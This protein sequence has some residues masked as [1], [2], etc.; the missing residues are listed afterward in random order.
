MDTR[1]HAI[2][3]ASGSARWL[4]CNPSARLEEMLPE[5]KFV[6]KGDFSY[7]EEGTLAHTLGE[8]KIRKH[9]DKITKVEFDKEYAKVKTSRYYN[10]EMENL[11]DDYALFVRSQ[12]GSDD[13][14]LVEV[15]V[16]FSDYVPQGF[17]SSDI[18]IIS[19][20]HIHVID[21]KHGVKF[22]DVKGNTQC[23]L[24][25][26]G[27]LSMFEEEY[28]NIRE[29]KYS[30]FQPRA[31]NIATDSVTVERLKEWGK[32]Y[33]KPRAKKAWVGE[34]DFLVGDW[35][36]YCKVKAQC[37]ARTDFNTAVA[38]MEFRDPPL[39]TDEEVAEVLSKAQNLKTWANDVED[40]A[41]TQAVNAGVLPNGY[42]LGTTKTHRKIVDHTMAATVLLEKGYKREEIFEKPGLKSVAQL[43]KLGA[44]NE[45]S[46]ILGA[47]IQRPE[48]SP[49]LVKDETLAEDFK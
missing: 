43:E 49:K 2:L 37:R 32:Y 12:A 21:Y 15:R 47:L 25:G 28:P 7:S 45:V 24:Y 19:K 26:I 17:G 18:V 48:G 5:V 16:D 29:V 39:L 27:A 31:N 36:G 22:V 35:C 34:G 8:L 46:G 33:V 1:A 44:K 23:R 3:S 4:N 10:E 14:V 38:R 42:K 6:G 41:L 13:I 40:F 30:I 11:T 9:Y 20:D